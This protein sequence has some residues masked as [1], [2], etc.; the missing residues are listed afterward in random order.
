MEVSV[1]ISSIST[2]AAIKQQAAADNQQ[3]TA[4]NQQAGSRQSTSC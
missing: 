4:D 3:A 2:Q 1:D